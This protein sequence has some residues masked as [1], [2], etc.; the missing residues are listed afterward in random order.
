MCD[1]CAQSE[2]VYIT[3]LK[4]FPP[5]SHPLLMRSGSKL[6]HSGKNCVSRLAWTMKMHTQTF[7][8]FFLYM[9]TR[10]QHNIDM[11]TLLRCW[12][13]NPESLVSHVINCEL[14]YFFCRLSTY[15]FARPFTFSIYLYK[16]HSSAHMLVWFSTKFAG[17]KQ[18]I[19]FFFK[20][21]QNIAE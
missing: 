15:T 11:T 3:Y 21:L 16:V 19:F 1:K 18:N 14:T 13:P 10:K 5:N 9:V 7:L 6:I 20:T 17:Y 2:N 4:L 12:I 8:A